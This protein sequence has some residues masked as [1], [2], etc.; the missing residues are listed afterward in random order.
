MLLGVEE[1]FDWEQTFPHDRSPAAF[2]FFLRE[3]VICLFGKVRVH[4]Q[5]LNRRQFD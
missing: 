3:S 4:C 1:V 2:P 5:R